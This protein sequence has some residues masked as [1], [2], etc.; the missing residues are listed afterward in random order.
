MSEVDGHQLFYL[1]CLHCGHYRPASPETLVCPQCGNDLLR[2]CLEC[3]RP[4]EN[5]MARSCGGCGSRY[6]EMGG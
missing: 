5:P 4:I 1:L 6:R 3:S 2:E